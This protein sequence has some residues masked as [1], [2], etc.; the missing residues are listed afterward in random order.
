MTDDLWD[1]L[2][3]TAVGVDADLLA[4]TSPRE[5]VERELSRSRPED[6]ARSLDVWRRATAGVSTEEGMRSVAHDLGAGTWD[7]PDG[8]SWLAW[9]AW[10]GERLRQAVDDPAT[11]LPRGA[12]PEWPYPW[13]VRDSAATSGSSLRRAVH[14]LVERHRDDV[15]A[16]LAD[17]AAGTRL[18]LVGETGAVVGQVVRTVPL[19]SGRAVA[20]GVR[21]TRAAV[22]L[23]RLDAGD[24][25]PAHEVAAVHAAEP[26]EDPRAAA[27]R[28]EL[29]AL[30]SFLGGWFNAADL[31]DEPGWDE[32]RALRSEPAA[33]LDRVAAEVPRLLARDEVELR[34]AVDALGCYAEPPHL[35]RWLEWTSWRIQRFDWG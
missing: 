27:W 7:P 19:R 25:G 17:P 35:R 12:V 5:A 14:V 20:S 16:W 18:H 11:I 29:P 28:R 10:Y 33:F 4:A 9:A 32:Q 34:A 24:A 13:R 30:T 8:S 15:A 2:L 1:E 3:T 6:V 26:R 21:T 31:D 23:R 22:V